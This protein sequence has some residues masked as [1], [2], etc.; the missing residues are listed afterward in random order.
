MNEGDHDRAL[1]DAKENLITSRKKKHD[2]KRNLLHMILICNQMVML[3]KLRN[4]F[5]ISLV[6]I[7]LHILTVVLN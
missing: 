6:N 2:F 4:N 5:I 1:T 3:L 7:R